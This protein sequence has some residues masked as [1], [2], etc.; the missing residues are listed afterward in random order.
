MGYGP[1]NGDAFF[2]LS[3]GTFLGGYGRFRA[4]ISPKNVKMDVYVRCKFQNPHVNKGVR[5]RGYG[6][7]F[8]ARGYAKGGT[9][10][11]FKELKCAVMGYGPSI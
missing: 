7:H 9:V 6:T 3:W 5:K 11:F 10:G 4:K 2:P 8:G 1:K